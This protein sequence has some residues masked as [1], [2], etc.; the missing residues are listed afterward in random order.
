MASNKEDFQEARETAT[1]STSESNLQTGKRKRVEEP[2]GNIKIQDE[3]VALF[4]TYRKLN[5]KLVRCEQHKKYLKRC[6]QRDM[7]PKTLRSSIMPQVPDTTPDFLLK[8]EAAQLEYGRTL[9]KLLIE[10]WE[11]RCE[12]ITEQIEL[13]KTELEEK[14][15]GDEMDH[16][17]TLVE[18]TKISVEEEIRK[19]PTGQNN[20]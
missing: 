10:Y 4:R 17:I 11:K 8:W 3:N 12:N 13:M 16:I 19:K 9:V 1:P 15:T 2:T 6:Q 7:V 14:T 20:Q 5:V 18:K